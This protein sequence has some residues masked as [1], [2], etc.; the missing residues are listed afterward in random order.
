MG[1]TAGLRRRINFVFAAAILG[2]SGYWAALK[3][4]EWSRQEVPPFYGFL[5]R[6]AAEIPADARILLLI[7]RDQRNSGLVHIFNSRMYPRVVYL[8]PAGVET[9]EGAA[10]WIRRKEIGWVV[11]P[12]GADY[13]P[14]KAY[15]RRL[16]DRP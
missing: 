13:D 3:A 15:I 4:I 11:S 14:R 1:S 8:P 12:G 5:E 10:E 6:V 16:D 9:L 7:P 2:V